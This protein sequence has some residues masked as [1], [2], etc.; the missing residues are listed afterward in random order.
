MTDKK[1]EALRMALEIVDEYVREHGYGKATLNA[2]REALVE[3]PANQVDDIP[4]QQCQHQWKNISSKRQTVY[5]CELCGV[6][7]FEKPW[8]GLTDEE[9]RW[10]RKRNQKHDAFAKAIE[11]ALKEKNN[12]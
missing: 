7:A 11:A 12:G 10:L 8:V 2:I 4:A 9:C 3:Q 6:Y 1:D 5:Q